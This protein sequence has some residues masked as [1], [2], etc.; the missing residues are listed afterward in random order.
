M[1]CDTMATSQINQSF[2]WL[3]LYRMKGIAFV[4]DPDGYW[5]ELVSRSPATVTNKY[6]LAQTMLR[7]KDPIKSLRFYCELLGKC[8]LSW[9]VSHSMIVSWLNDCNMTWP[10]CGRND[11]VARGSYGPRGGLGILIVFPQGT[12]LP[13]VTEAYNPDQ[14]NSRLNFEPVIE[15]T[16]NHGTELVEEFKYV[17]TML[18]PVHHAWR[19]SVI[20]SI[21]KRH[22]VGW[23]TPIIASPSDGTDDC[24]CLLSASLPII[25]SFVDW[26]EV[27]QGSPM[28]TIYYLSCIDIITAMIKMRDSHEALDT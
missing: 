13:P 27:T 19:Q 12:P 18:L 8:S 2:I 20:M 5:I 4:L 14:D 6:T 15:L 21:M 11:F 3:E 25:I 7:V 28:P 23:L 9:W 22:V 17:Q 26:I 16:H 10:L 1:K 24:R